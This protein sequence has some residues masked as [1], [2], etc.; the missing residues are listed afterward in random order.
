MQTTLAVQET[1]KKALQ[2]SGEAPDIINQEIIGVDEQVQDAASYA[3]L[4]VISISKPALV[5]N[6]N[7]KIK[8]ANSAFYKT[9]SADQQETEG[10]W[11]LKILPK[12]LSPERN[13]KKAKLSIAQ[14]WKTALTV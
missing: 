1:A 13:W 2:N 14:Y 10:C 6:E 4:I 11:L 5:L 3:E 7:L 8:K 9:F 12:K